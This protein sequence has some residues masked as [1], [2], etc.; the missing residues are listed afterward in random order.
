M[1]EKMGETFWEKKWEKISKNYSK[2]ILKLMKKYKNPSRKRFFITKLSIRFIKIK[3][4]N[5]IFYV[6]SGTY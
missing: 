1:G 5:Q 6:L 2:A 4:K 3:L